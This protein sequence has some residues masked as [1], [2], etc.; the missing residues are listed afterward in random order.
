[1]HKI[2]IDRFLR[3][4]KL[5]EFSGGE[6]FCSRSFTDIISYSSSDGRTHTI[7]LFISPAL[8]IPDLDKIARA[9]FRFFFVF[10]LFGEELERNPVAIVVF[11][12]RRAREKP[13]TLRYQYRFP[14]CTSQMHDHQEIRTSSY[15][16]LRGRLRH[17][18]AVP[19]LQLAREDEAR[20]R[21]ACK[22]AFPKIQPRTRDTREKTRGESR[23]RNAA[24]RR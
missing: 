23:S 12:G 4:G 15:G 5:A 8:E 11:R 19:K 3:R 10:S 24:R 13:N 9:S 22:E 14:P 6:I 20:C 7:E 21:L 1:M 2:C 18:D 16:E 17:R